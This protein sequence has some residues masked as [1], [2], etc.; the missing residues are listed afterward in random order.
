MI[1]WTG[2]EHCWDAFDVFYIERDGEVL[3][4]LAIGVRVLYAGEG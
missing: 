1:G 2:V 4:G 3:V